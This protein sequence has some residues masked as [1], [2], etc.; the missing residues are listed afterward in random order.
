MVCFP[1]ERVGVLKLDWWGYDEGIGIIDKRSKL[2]LIEFA[3]NDKNSKNNNLPHFSA[4]NRT[5]E[6]RKQ[7]E[8]HE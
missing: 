8:E 5:W 4:P 6:G 3:K 1:S 7:A 2:P